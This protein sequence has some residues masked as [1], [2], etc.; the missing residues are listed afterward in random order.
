MNN[1]G[2][3]IIK[4]VDV[5]EI[6]NDFKIP[7]AMKFVIANDIKSQILQQM[8][9]EV[10][11][12]A[13]KELHSTRELYLS[14]IS[15]DDDGLELIGEIPNAIEGGAPAFDMKQGFEMSSKR[16]LSKS[17]G[18]YLTVPFRIYAP[19]AS[20]RVTHMTWAIYRAVNSD[21]AYDAGR[22]Q[23]RPAFKDVFTGATYP[24]YNHKS[25]ILSGINK[26]TNPTTNMNTYH[27]FRR[28]SDKSSPNS[29][30]HKGFRPHRFFDR[31]WASLPIDKIFNRTVRKYM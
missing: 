20:N 8:H 1:S 11:R 18:W 21:R 9:K 15:V 16:K 10:S 13:N 14:S 22:P 2:G 7:N 3:I 26:M 27:T 12:L 24:S 19:T 30:V 5:Q 25:S 28:V 6:L 29:W 4:T 23:S 31:A 17:G